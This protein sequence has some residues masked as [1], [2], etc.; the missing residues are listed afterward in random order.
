MRRAIKYYKDFCLRKAKEQWHSEAT[1]HSTLSSA[2][3]PLQVDPLD[4]AHHAQL[5]YVADQLQ[6]HEQRS[7]EGRRI[8]NRVKWLKVG[9]TG[10]SEFFK[11]TRDHSGASSITELVDEQ[12]TVFTDQADLERLCGSY[13]EKLYKAKSQSAEQDGVMAQIYV[14][15]SDRLAPS[16]KAALSALIR[17]SELEGALKS[18][19][20]G[21]ALGLDSAITEFFKTFWSLIKD[22]G[23]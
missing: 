15:L 21:R 4:L 23:P 6:A 8:C 19:S 14:G 16:C 13:Y 11:I 10:L 12:D 5:S 3:T 17:M 1:L 9:D 2:V 20:A 18:M 22:Q 7:A